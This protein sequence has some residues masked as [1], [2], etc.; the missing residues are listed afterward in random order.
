MKT[1]RL[2]SRILAAAFVAAIAHAPSAY[3]GG[4]LENCS[5]GTPMRW[6]AGGV[7]IPFNPDQGDLGPL[8][9]VAAVAAVQNAFDQWGNLPTSTASYLAGVELP[10]DVDASNFLPYLSPTAPDGLSAIVFDDDGAIFDL[11]FGPGSG[12]LG[13]A[14]PEWTDTTTCSI[15]EGVSFLNGPSFGDPT[16]AL[17]V[18]VHEFGHYSNLAHTA[19]NGQILL[20]DF[21]GPTPND[22]FPLV[23]LAGLIETMYPFY[24]GP[25]AG[26]SSP[27]LDDIQT[28]STLY[29]AAGYLAANGAITGT[30]YAPNGATKLSGVNVIARNVA[31][32]FADAVA[33]MSGDR[34]D[35][36]D[37]ADAFTGTYRFNGLTPGASYAVFVDQILDGGFSTP[38]I[39]LPGAEDF[40][41]GSAESNNI[42]SPDDPSVFTGVVVAAATTNSGINIIFNGFKPGDPLPVGDDGFVQL[43][44][45]FKFKVCGQEYD[46]VFV[47]ANG[48][49]TFG[50]GSGD[51]SESVAELL[52]GLGGQSSLLAPPRIAGLWDDLNVLD[53][54]NVTFDQSSHS[55]TVRWDAVPEFG[56]V[57]ANTFSITLKRPGNSAT[58]DYG[59]LS[60]TDGLAG[61]TCGS[62]ITSGFEEEQD[63]RRFGH[64]RVIAMGHETAAFELFANADNDLSDF[65]LTFV[66]FKDGFKDVFEG[67]HGNNSIAK[68]TRVFLPF[69]TSKLHA[70]TAV[71]PLGGDVDYYRFRAKG[72]DILA[73]EVVRGSPD[74][75][76][77]LFN[78]STGALLA[79]DDDGGCCGVGGL[80][81]LLVGI[82]PTVT[83]IDLAVAVTSWN[84]ADFDGSGGVTSGRYVLYLNSYQGTILPAGDDTSTEVPISFPFRYQG[85]N[86]T[87]VFVNS[88]G[89]LT[90]GAGDT[91]F[92][93]SVADFLAGSPRIAP[94]WNDLFAPDGLVIAEQKPFSLDLHY[95]S[96]P[97]F[98]SLSANYFDASLIFGGGIVLNWGP[99]DRL[100]GLVGLTEGGGATDPGETNLSNRLLIP[101]RRTTYEL[102]EAPSLF[103][104]SFQA[105]LAIP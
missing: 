11:L 35:S 56:P 4:P 22:T 69:D 8:A 40:Y 62:E 94:L 87:S 90:F 91:D 9:H 13:F 24:F 39:S 103:D 101:A 33:A 98:G 83:S 10:V 55:L 26:F 72:G 34:T 14:G 6:P 48:S 44:M 79:A 66:D 58:I 50:A 93:E 54:G 82:A 46:S 78:A 95:V 18:M 43:F 15:L 99:T 32:P 64:H 63:L 7:N 3:A 92:T 30:I 16:E 23:P 47:N 86:R 85:A 105:L 25:A 37:Q 29:P 60:A 97:A 27:H 100:G 75:M 84:D 38:P 76:V 20:G 51:F 28:I 68:A 17:D 104:L 53:G 96:V 41:N 71:S 88:N 5:S 36:T 102:F 2:A 81:R 19:V 70:F 59:A 31:N 42:T 52:G 49:L 80:S 73:I 61:L 45:P 12:I 74:T 65:H 77:G 89:N 21:T 67:R 1:F 57:G